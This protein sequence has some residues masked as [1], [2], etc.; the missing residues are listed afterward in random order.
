MYVTISEVISDDNKHNLEDKLN[1]VK[2]SIDL[3]SHKIRTSRS[4]LVQTLTETEQAIY[5]ALQDSGM[6]IAMLKAKSTSVRGDL[7]RH[8]ESEGIPSQDQDLTDV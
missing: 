6:Y 5:K 7:R 3:R 8:L 1:E 2:D 4:T